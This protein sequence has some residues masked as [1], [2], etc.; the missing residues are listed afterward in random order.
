MR[1]VARFTGPALVTCLAWTAACGD[2]TK[3]PVAASLAIAGGDAQRAPLGDTLP[4]PLAVTVTGSDGRPFAGATVTWGVAPAGTATFLPPT[5]ES[6]PDGRASTIVAVGFTA[7]TLSITAT[8][9][10]VPPASF[11]LDAVEPCSFQR[12]YTIG[13]T[14]TGVLATRDCLLSGGSYIDYDSTTNASAEWLLLSETSTAFDAFLTLEDTAGLV[15]AAGVDTGPGTTNAPIRVLAATGPYV[16]G[17]SSR[18]AAR[19]GPYTLASGPTASDVT[20]CDLVWLTRGVQTSQ[21]IQ[22]T[23]CPAGGLR[24]DLFVLVLRA[25]QTV[26]FTESSTAV[27]AYL[28]L[29]RV[30]SNGTLTFLGFNDNGGGGTNALL[31]HTPALTGIYVVGAETFASGE[32]GAYV[33]SVSAPAQAA[34]SASSPTLPHASRDLAVTPEARLSRL[35][36]SWAN[37][38]ASGA[39]PAKTLP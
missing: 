13:A 28:E 9:A 12:P 7:G 15:L 6:G 37:A 30:N 27:D 20:N 17:A 29:Y 26:T 5:S 1:S 3:P 36:R 33:L 24:F 23:D 22:A 2:S 4:Q 32:T 19:T 10:S 8:V 14:V 38:A 39:Q 34:S 18:L 25:G 16:I 11:S 35:P 31:T 21:Q